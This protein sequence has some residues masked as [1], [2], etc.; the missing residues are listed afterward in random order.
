MALSIQTNVN[1][2]VAQENLSVNTTFQARTIQRLTSGYRINSSS[3]D[4]AGL[5]V[6]NKFRSD[7]AELTQGVRNANDAIS[8]LQIIDGG[9]SN[10]SNIMDRLKTLATQASSG[11]FTGNRTTVNNEFQTLLS[12]IDRQATN[13]KL[14]TGGQYNSNLTAYIGGAGGANANAQV[15]VDLTGSAIDQTGLGLTGLQVVGGG[16]K[17]AAG[18]SN[19]VRLDQSATTFL[20]SNTHQDFTVKYVDSNNMMQSATVT[21]VGSTTSTGLTGSQAV[22][23]VNAGL[24][25]A[26]ITSIQAQIGSDGMLAFSGTK[27]FQVTAGGALDS[28]N[29][30]SGAQVIAASGAVAV[31][32]GTT[33]TTAAFTGLSMGT[34]D[35]SA[36]TG[37]TDAVTFTV[38][39]S[40]YTATLNGDATQANGTTVFNGSNIG[41]AVAG[42][43]SFLQANNLNI[44][45]FANGG[46][47][48]E[49][50]GTTAF[51][52]T[53]SFAA[54]AAG[55]GAAGVASGFGGAGTAVTTFSMTAADSKASLTGN[56]LAA[57]DAIN[58]A[59][60]KLGGVEGKVGA[61]QNQ[62]HYSISLAT[63]QITNF[64]SAESQ[65]RDADVAAEAANLTKAQVLQQASM[66]AMAQANSAP[67]AVLA[68]LRG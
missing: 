33:N 50:Q 2:M 24:A 62:L 65:I 42:L 16:S 10:V 28:S 32:L 39:A 26:G 11:T 68:L 40:S 31:N 17:M 36:N 60:S 44:R 38:G 48:I 58:N 59:V 18:S 22:D 15:T 20:A 30:A 61:G 1:S 23:A 55:T 52:M 7:S 37:S 35:P 9:V 6:A 29:V 13:V 47:T 41:N 45:A 4:A 63:S 53:N 14:N 49:F 8:Q 25:K 64:A 51:T 12:E 5:A 46:S 21:A 34:G 27:A 57:V 66:A 3:D 67:Q 54:G 43:N 56:A 19:T